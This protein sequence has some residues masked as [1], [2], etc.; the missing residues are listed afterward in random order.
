ML[1]L[2]AYGVPLSQKEHQV[3]GTACIWFLRRWSM[4]KWVKRRKGGEDKVT[5]RKRMHAVLHFKVTLPQQDQKFIC[6]SKSGLEN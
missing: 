6:V 4:G 1:G 2:Q 3:V 5:V